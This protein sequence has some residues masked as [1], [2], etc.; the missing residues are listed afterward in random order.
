MTDTC[1]NGNDYNGEHFGARIS[2]VFVILAASAIGSFLPLI[3]L[4]SRVKVPWWVFFIVRYI[5]SGV[6]TATGFIHLLHLSRKS[7]SNECL[8]EPF[9]SFPWAFGITL[10]GLM[11]MLFFD[12]LAHYKIEKKIEAKTVCGPDVD[13][14][15]CLTVDC[16][17]KELPTQLIHSYYHQIL[18]SFV[19][20]FGII[21]HSVFIGLSLAI[22]GEEFIPL[23]IAISFHQMCE[24]MG[25]GVRFGLTPW[26]HDKQYMPWVLSFAYSLT[27]PLAIAVGLG[28]RNTYSKGSRTALITNGVFDAF[29]AGILIYNSVV[30]LMAYD[31]MYSSDFKQKNGTK[32]MILAFFFLSVGAGAMSLIAKWA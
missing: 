16:A 31:F 7:L 8:G 27:T 19:L 12:M 32:K 11:T 6:I 23:F 30:E 28:V 22:A 20:E 17:T 2:S 1:N 29:C 18:N 10:M 5:G 14:E 24:G 26:P 25:L 3:L 21:F 15:S 13:E 9:T 4:K